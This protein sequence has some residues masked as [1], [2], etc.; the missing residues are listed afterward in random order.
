MAYVAAGRFDGYFQENLSLWDI[1][2]GMILIS[3]AG[4]N[5]NSID[6]SKKEKIEILASSSSISEKMLE[7]LN[8]F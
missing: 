7:K 5:L 3:E 6:L 2:A 4:G 8:K 1:A